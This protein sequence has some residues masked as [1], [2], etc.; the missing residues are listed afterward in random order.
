MND[1]RTSVAG[2]LTAL[3]FSVIAT[4]GIAL[5]G[6]GPVKGYAGPARSADQVASIRPSPP[7]TQIGVVVD[8]VDGMAVD[9]EI[10]LS[11]LP[12]T[13]RL[14]MTL[15]PYSL[16]EMSES[17][18]GPVA[19]ERTLYNLEWKTPAEL[20]VPVV[21]GATYEI[22]GRWNEPMYEVRVRRIGD[23]VVV[24]S[25]SFEAVHHVQGLPGAGR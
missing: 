17:G 18:G 6:C 16:D 2:V 13:R 12:G 19:A 4:S 9:A 21:A 5:G 22:L 20:D 10:D 3:L 7:D 14:G 8:A 1:F 15:V 24:A 25:R 11:V 23:G